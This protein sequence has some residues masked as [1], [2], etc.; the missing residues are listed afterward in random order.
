MTGGSVLSGMEGGGLALLLWWCFCIRSSVNCKLMEATI[1]Q[2]SRR[3]PHSIFF[4]AFHALAVDDGGGRTG[5]SLLSFATLF[6]E[7]VVDS[8]QRA[9]IRP[10]IEVVIDR[11]SRRQCFRDRAPLTAGRAHIHQAVP[12]LPHDHPALATARLSP[13]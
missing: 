3:L 11:A 1:L 10:Q 12:H 2:L 6:I 8:C 4:R 9:V 5:L 13:R 7:R